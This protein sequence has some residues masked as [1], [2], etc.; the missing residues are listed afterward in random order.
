MELSQFLQVLQVPVCLLIIQQLLLGHLPFILQERAGAGGFVSGPNQ[1]LDRE[2]A[3]YFD[4]SASAFTKL[5]Q[6][7]VW[8]C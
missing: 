1:Y 5:Y 3:M 2:K 8:V 7:D 4:A 6:V